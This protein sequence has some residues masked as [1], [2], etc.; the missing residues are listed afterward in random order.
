MPSPEF[1]AL[2]TAIKA[3]PRP[4]PAAGGTD[5]EQARASMDL[6]LGAIPL[7]DGVIAG[8]TTA[9]GRPAVWV[10][11]TG[12]AMDR[13]VL[14]FHGGGYRA[15][16]AQAFSGF[17]SQVAVALG[18]PLLVLDYRLAPEHPFP[19]AVEDGADAYRWLLDQGYEPHRIA[20]LGDTAGGGLAVSTLLAVRTAGLP[21]PAAA[22]CLS[23]MVD[24]TASADSYDRCA[25]TDPIYSRAQ[26]L[27]A[28]ADYLNGTDPHDPLASPVFA[29]LGDLAPLLVHASDREVLV[30]DA[31]AL[32]RKVTAAGG[33]ATLELWPDLIHFWHLF[34]PDIPEATAA[35]LGVADFLYTHLT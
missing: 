16:S 32:A 28:A 12:A 19:A 33:R 34:V 27:A 6:V 4:E 31:V 18:A 35:V 3:S 2:L 13:A 5:V 20:F 30:D 8:E 22:V 26:A 25:H 15:G 9:G 21:Q 17:A 14:Y 7:A 29:D 11:P 24:L 10:R 23:P 1:E